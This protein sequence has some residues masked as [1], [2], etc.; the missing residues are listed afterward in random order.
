MVQQPAQRGTDIGLIAIQPAQAQPPGLR[1]GRGHTGVLR[2]LRVPARVTLRQRRRLLVLGEPL[3][4]V[5]ADHLQQPVARLAGIL[6]RHHQRLVDQMRQ[7]VHDLLAG[8]A[9]VAA[10]LLGSVKAEAPREHTEAPQQ[11]GLGR[12]QEPV[13]P[14]QRRLQRL[15]PRLERSP[16]VAQQP[17][18]RHQA[19]R[20]LGGRQRACT[21]SRQLDRKRH[22]V[23]ATAD[24]H[25]VPRV[26]LRQHELRLDG[27]RALDEQAH[28]L[29]AQQLG[30]R[31]RAG[32]VRKR[33]RRHAPHQ[34]AG[35]RERLAARGQHLN[36]RTAAQDLLD[37]LGAAG[38]QVLAVVEHDQQLPPG[39]PVDQRRGARRASALR[40]AGR[41]RDRVG[42]Q[43]RPGERC[44]ID[45]PGSVAKLLALACRHLEG[46]ARLARPCGSAE[47][48]QRSTAKQPDD[49]RDRRL[50]PDEYRQLDRQI[51]AAGGL[52]RV[53][54]EDHRRP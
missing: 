51:V 9:A 52:R 38:D 20:D 24:P 53:V 17:E 54:R 37:R 34:L 1:A 42:D 13:A 32:G 12:L 44:Q 18:G 33:E 19:P 14:V 40:E 7:Q 2:Q 45:E 30:R 11:P 3:A 5:L 41:G 46:E 36:R 8:K 35:Q 47:R 4:R 16:L 31:Q 22:P 6:A 25:D 29:V 39:Q 49:L 27:A 10:D 50:T 28:R 21:R 43:L 15:L 26:G 23:E 48:D